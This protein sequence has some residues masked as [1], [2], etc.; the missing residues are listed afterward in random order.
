MKKNLRILLSKGKNSLKITTVNAGE[1]DTN[2]A[3]IK[4]YDTRRTYEVLT[5]L[6]VG[7]SALINIYKNAK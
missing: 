1:L 5:N 7:K 4:L 3:K 6:E 2:T